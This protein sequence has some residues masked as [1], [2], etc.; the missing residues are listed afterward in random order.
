MCHTLI[1]THH[2]YRRARLHQ[3]QEAVRCLDV[4]V[5]SRGREGN[6]HD[7]LLRRVTSQIQ[8]PATPAFR[9]NSHDESD[10]SDVAKSACTYQAIDALDLLDHLRTGR[11]VSTPGVQLLESLP[12]V[13]ICLMYARQAGEF[14]R[15][16]VAQ[17]QHKFLWQQGCR[18]AI[19]QQRQLVGRCRRRRHLRDRCAAMCCMCCRLRQRKRHWRREGSEEWLVPRGVLPIA[20]CLLVSRPGLCP[21]GG[22]PARRAVPLTA[23]TG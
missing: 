10:H 22:H 17:H 15:R 13:Q 23:Q 5:T 18:N 6:V 2:H 12:G 11:G 7:A 21:R 9:P 19:Q 1:A 4:P 16:Q 20:S 3:Q 14:H 8:R